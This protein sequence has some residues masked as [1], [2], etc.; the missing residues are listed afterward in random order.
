MTGWKQPAGTITAKQII[1]LYNLKPGDVLISRK[2]LEALGYIEP[3]RE[4][5]QTY[6]LLKGSI[7]LTSIQLES[8]YIAA[9]Y[10]YNMPDDYIKHVLLPLCTMYKN[11]DPHL[12]SNNINPDISGLG[13][14]RKQ[15]SYIIS[16]LPEN[17]IA[18][19]SI[20]FICHPIHD[21]IVTTLSRRK[22]LDNVANLLRMTANQFQ[23]WF[24]PE[25]DTLS[26]LNDAAD[27]IMQVKIPVRRR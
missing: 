24:G 2:R 22:R 7:P 9:N 17:L 23:E 16:I 26:K 10:T 1:N 12:S 25:T 21:G 8:E 14:A 5:S 19:T 15:L 27:L 6:R 11:L 20:S 18:S 4:G 3:V 13:D